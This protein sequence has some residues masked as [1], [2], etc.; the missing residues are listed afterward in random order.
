MYIRRNYSQSFY[1]KRRQNHL[2]LTLTL[3]ALIVAVLVVVSSQFNSLQA[4]AL[5]TVGVAPAP[6]PLPGVLANSAAQKFAAGDLEGARAE[7][8][9]AVEEQPNNI[10]YLYEY[11]RVL[12]ELG[13]SEQAAELGDRAIRAAPNDV[14]GYALKANALAWSDPGN[15]VPIA[16]NGRSIDPSFSAVYAAMAIAYN[17]LAYYDLALENGLKAIEVNPNDADAYRA[18]AWPLIYTGQYELAIQYLETAI[19]INPNLTGP[20]FQLAFE[21]K[22][23][24]NNPEM[25][26]AIYE[27]ILSMNPS[28]EDAAK[29]NLRMCETYANVDEADFSTAEPFCREAIR[30]KPDYGSAYRELGRMR[31]NR[32]NYEGAIEAFE[33]CVALGATDIECWHLRGLA[34]F[35]MGQCDQAWTVLNEAAIRAAEQGEDPMTIEDIS[36]GLYNTRVKCPAYQNMPEPTT[37]PPTP[38]PPTPIGGL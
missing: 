15:A 12:L 27:H 19:S 35:W 34:H 31:Y 36:T 29:A 30:I 18:M 5:K 21:Y 3:I 24:A 14:R 10:N 11:G 28:V 38:I 6:T 25:A 37:I 2:L 26:A 9:K 22:H 16:I 4:A 8:A 13:Q 20:Y 17:N 32:R 7:F 1:R 23:R 33:T